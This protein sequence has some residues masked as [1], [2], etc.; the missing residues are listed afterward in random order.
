[1]LNRDKTQ[2]E[3]PQNPGQQ[4]VAPTPGAQPSNQRSSGQGG[5]NALTQEKATESNAIQI[6]QI[7]LPKGGGALKGIDEKF[8]VNAA[9][10]T[11]SFSIPLPLSPGRNGFSPSLALSYNSGGGNSA[12]GLGWDLG[13]PSIQRKTDRRLPRYLDGDDE[14]VF[15]FTGVEDLVPFLEEKSSGD[16]Q[17]LKS[18][19]DGYEVAR[20]RPRIEG[21]FARIEK[22][23]HKDHGTYWKVTTPDNVATLFGRDPGARIVDPEDPNR[24]FQ[25][26]PEFS[27]DDKGNWIQYEYKKGNDENVPNVL[28]EK[29]RLSGIA[30]F[31]NAYLKRVRYGNRTPYYAN[32]DLPYDPQSPTDP[33]HFFELVLDYG[34]HDATT[35]TP[36]ETAGQPWNYRADPFSTYRAGFEI[37]T[38]RLCRRALIFHHFEELGAEPCL[39]RSLSFDYEPSSINE[40]GQTEATYLASI[41]QTGTIRKADGTY[42]SKSLPPMEFDYQRLNWDTSIKTV[43]QESIIHTPVGLTNNYQWVD[44]YG[45]GISGILSEHSDG[46]FYKSN[47]GDVQDVGKSHFTPAKKVVPK[48]SFTGLNSGVLSLQDL[49]ANGEKQMVI[50]TPEVRGF[51]ELDNDDEWKSFKAFEEITNLDLRD[52]NTRLIDLNGDGQPELVITKE[53]AFVW[54]ASKGKKGYA[55]AEF[56]AKAFDEEKGPAIVFADSQQSIFLADMSGDGLTD[57]VR[58]RNGEICYWANLGYGRFSAKI[59]MTNAPWFDHPDLFNPQYL[60]LADVS[61]TGATDIIYTG[62]KNFKAFINLNGNAWSDAHE[63]E[64]FFPMDHNSQLS[65]IDLLGTGTSCIVWSSDLPG[66]AHAPMKYID[67]MGSKKPHVLTHY[68]NNLGK[69]TRL[70]YKSS[71]HFYLKDKLAG[72]PWITKLPFPVQVVTKLIVEEK[73]TDVRF[74]DLRTC[75]F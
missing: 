18:A 21:G 46:W 4:S 56:I 50:N 38:N 25:W 63:I 73:I 12:F 57:I 23:T 65:V 26:L 69:E 8:A 1:M 36:S 22:I 14:D 54:H 6:P 74:I 55:A 17:P 47:L 5:I 62:Q 19:I 53:N 40:S 42:A 33:E 28:H 49:D 60:H 72:K 51:F 31:T 71:T 41:T 45:E 7:S 29:N 66:H 61:G 48:P 37:R 39:V 24:I 2:N 13:Y 68:R 10:G 43:S 15:M 9:N 16:W 30:Q 34:E 20:Y 59:S 64:P 3:N 44:L 52:P 27:Y 32:P 70:E 11:S 75:P 58:I 67:L 35:P